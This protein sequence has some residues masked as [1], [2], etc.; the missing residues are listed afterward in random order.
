MLR[1]FPFAVSVADWL[2]LAPGWMETTESIQILIR[3]IRNI[4]MNKARS[5]SFYQKGGEQESCFGRT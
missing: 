5:D 4:R 1:I 2:T 3:R